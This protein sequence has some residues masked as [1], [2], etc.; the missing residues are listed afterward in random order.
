MNN[1]IS[2]MFVLLAA[3]LWGSTATVGKLVLT[4]LNNLQVSLFATLFATASLYVVV[5]LQGKQKIIRTYTRN[6]YIT[7]AWMGFLGVFAYQLCLYGALKL[8]PAQEAFLINYMWPIMVVIFAVVLLKEKVTLKKV[9]GIVFAFFGVTLVIT[10]GDFSTLKFDNLLGI[11][12][13]LAG[14]VVYGAFSVLGKKQSYEKFTSMMFYYAFAFFYALVTTFLFSK[15]PHLSWYQLAGLAWLGIFTSGLA[16]V[17]WFLALQYGDT[18]KMSNIIFLTPFISLIY[19]HLILNERVLISSVLG[20]CIIV[21]S[22]LIQSIA[23]S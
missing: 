16:F 5:F 21:A 3:L 2:Y 23:E 6:D 7:F 1:Y 11:A 19:I 22:I 8:L 20:L 15:V 14:S 13:A 4:N 18:T 12:L 10:K 17:F 9:V